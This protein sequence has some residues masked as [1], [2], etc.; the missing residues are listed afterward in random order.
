M[1]HYLI[2]R[3]SAIGDVAMAFTWVM[4]VARANPEH[5]FTFLTQTFLTD[6]L[7]APPPNLEAMAIDIKGEDKPFSA[8]L[9]YALRLRRERFDVVIDLHDVLRTKVLRSVLGLCSK[10]KVYHLR[11]PR[12]ARKALL[13]AGDKALAPEVPSMSDLYA[14]ALRSAGLRVPEA[15]SYCTPSAQSLTDLRLDHAELLATMQGYR[16]VGL[17][18]FA[19]T[20]SKTY[21]LALCEEVLQMLTLRGD[22]WV[23]LFGGGAKEH[24]LLQEWAERYP[25]CTSMSRQMNLS[26]E[27]LV[28][29]SL[30]VMI[31]MDSAN[32]HL[33]AMMGT[34]VV[35]VWCAT[36]P[37]AGFSAIGQS[38]ADALGAEELACRPCSIFGQV[39]HCIHGDMPCRRAVSPEEVVRVALAQD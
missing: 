10:A 35:S 6:L 25:R 9:R 27:L 20:E 7:I 37:S 28:M 33:A 2:T 14:Q 22:V 39:K 26:G 36:H 15:P 38:R 32:A 29:S 19:S 4:T 3:L 24:A 30:Q 31:S 8:L 21:D 23:L 11:K 18:P 12:R 5:Q 1:A 16:L 13:R 17:A 34:R